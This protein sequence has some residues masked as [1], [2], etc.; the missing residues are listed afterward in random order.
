ML[1]INNDFKPKSNTGFV[2]KNKFKKTDSQP[3]LKGDVYLDRQLLE[4]LLKESKD[5]VIKITLSAYIKQTKDADKY[6]SV[7]A[8]KPYVKPFNSQF[9]QD[10]DD[11]IPF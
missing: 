8:S 4:L 11:D 9:P 10:K 2:F 7:Y 6:L 5:S 3:D 1:T